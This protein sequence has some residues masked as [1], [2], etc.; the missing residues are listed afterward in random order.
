LPSETQW[1]YAIRG[2]TISAYYWGDTEKD[3]DKFA[4]FNENSRDKTHLVGLKLPNA[5]G[6]YDMSG[7]VWEWVQD[8]WHENYNQAPIDGSA[9]QEQN[10]G[11]FAPGVCCAAVPGAT[12]RTGCARRTV[13]GTIRTTAA[14]LSASVSPRTNPFFFVLLPFAFLFFLF[15]RPLGRSRFFLEGL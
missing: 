1:E 14:T 9:W 3:A 10:E 11:D 2:G 12:L 5:F 8:C 6:L 7:N 15:E 13:A 4:W